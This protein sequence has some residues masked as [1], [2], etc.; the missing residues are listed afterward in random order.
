VGER[1]WRSG[2]AR[3]RQTCGLRPSRQLCSDESHYSISPQQDRRTRYTWIS[4][5]LRRFRFHTPA[6]IRICRTLC[7]V[8]TTPCFSPRYSAANVGPKSGHSRF[9]SRATFA[10]TAAL[11][12]R[13]EVRPRSR[14]RTRQHPPS[15][16]APPASVPRARLASIASPLASA[17]GVPFLFRATPSTDPAL[18]GSSAPPV[19]FSSRQFAGFLQELLTL[20]R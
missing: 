6:S 20:L 15:P 10:R 2:R 12:F 8:V 4:S 13:F 11:N 18:F 16:A 5:I 7:L 9:S 14:C 19:A 1:V 17:S 3:P